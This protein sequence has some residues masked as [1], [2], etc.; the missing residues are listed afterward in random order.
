MRNIGI[1]H[2][3]AAA[4]AALIGTVGFA[5][6]DAFAQKIICWK[7]KSGKVV[8]CGDIVPPEYQ[9]SGTKQLDKRGVTRGTTDSAEEVAKRKAQ[10]QETAKQRAE[11]QKKN[12]EQRRQDS[13]LLNKIGRASCRERV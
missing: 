13:A 6:N 4:I 2:L 11:E 10:E 7:D 9:E 3:T 12:A 1:R 5:A 8:G